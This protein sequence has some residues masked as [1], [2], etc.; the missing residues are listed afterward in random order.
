MKTTDGAYHDQHNI[1]ENEKPTAHFK[2]LPHEFGKLED[3]IDIY[4]NRK[5]K[6][7]T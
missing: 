4:K 1:E 7:E 6:Y 3:K 2:I 5:R